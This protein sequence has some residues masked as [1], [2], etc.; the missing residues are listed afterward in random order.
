[1]QRS[2]LHDKNA[3]LG[4]RF[5]PFSGWEMPVQFEGIIP[6]H[7]AVR[8]AV[9]VFDISH[10]GEFFVKGPE[11]EDWLNGMLTN[12]VAE[13]GV[14]D[15]QY[16]LMLN[17]GGGVIDDLIAYRIAPKEFL[18][19]VNAAKIDEDIT[20]CRARLEGDVTIEDRS[21]EFAALAVQG[22][23]MAELFDKVF[24]KS[25]ALPERNTVTR[26][27]SPSGNGYLCGT[28][29]TGEN[30]FELVVPAADGVHWYERVLDAGAV[31]CGLGARDSL[32]LEMAYPLNGSDLSPDHTPL[33][34][35]LAFAVDMEKGDFTG[36]DILAA[37]KEKGLP[38]RLAGLEMTA[39]GPP[40]RAHYKLFHGGSEVGELSS[41]G[42]SPTLG[43]GIGLAYLPRKLSKIDTELE[44]DIR[45]KRFP[46]KVVKKPFYQPAS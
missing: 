27:A 8:S 35:G 29:Y 14:G 37:Q 9:G 38:K 17:D 22:P 31:P 3:E 1:M 41:G 26:V 44:L 12:N 20:W 30:G 19:V 46:A 36:R 4:G 32:R 2:P 21:P 13:L 7:K 6:E 24:T 28:G 16:T 39:K 45:G 10:M 11:A 5:V 33:E 18:L 43:K 25:I 15:A 34:A 23:A 40:P 42:F